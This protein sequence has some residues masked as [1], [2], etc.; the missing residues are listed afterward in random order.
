MVNNLKNLRKAR[1]ISVTELAQKL[2]MSQG[3]LTKIENGQV[4]MKAETAAALAEILQ[5]T[6]EQ[7]LADR[8]STDTTAL[9]TYFNLPADARIFPV[10]DDTMAPTLF[11]GDIAVIR[12]TAVQTGNGLY[13]LQIQ[14]REVIRRLQTL[15]DGKVVL[16]CDNQVYQPEYA[17]L[18]TLQLQG[19]VISKISQTAISR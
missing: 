1:N 19:R 2:G 17:A 5:C 3:N 14:G 11:P 12:P 18:S 8:D 6:L 16:L 13:V 9:A 15:S 10:R 4:D 7:L